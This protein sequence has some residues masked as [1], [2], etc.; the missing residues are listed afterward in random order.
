[1][2]DAG[3]SSWLISR[4]RSR[5]GWQ[6]RSGGEEAQNMGHDVH[7][8]RM[9]VKNCL[10]LIAFYFTQ[11]FCSV[12]ASTF[13][14]MPF[15]DDPYILK[16]DRVESAQ[17]LHGVSLFDYPYESYTYAVVHTVPAGEYY[18]YVYDAVYSFT[19]DPGWQAPAAHALGTARSGGYFATSSSRSRS[20]LS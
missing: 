10:F 3:I 7:H 9:L 20:A 18:R 4:A 17:Y 19:T 6:G 15:N 11:S 16:F 5:E 8:R 2:R 12:A 1:M 13:N 14:Q